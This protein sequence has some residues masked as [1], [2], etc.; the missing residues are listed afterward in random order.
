MKYIASLVFL[1]LAAP[2]FAETY[3]CTDKVDSKKGYTQSFYKRGNGDYFIFREGSHSQIQ[4]WRFKIAF[5]DDLMLLLYRTRVGLLRDDQRTTFI[6]QINK[7]NGNVHAIVMH[8][9]H[10]TLGQ[11]PLEGHCEVVE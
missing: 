1:L 4:N 7:T 8:L 10:G 2:I 3:V 11:P 9:R 6:T 5:E